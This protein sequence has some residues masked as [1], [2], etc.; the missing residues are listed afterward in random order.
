MTPT[1]PTL[2]ELSFQSANITVDEDDS[3][4]TVS[5]LLSQ[6]SGDTVTVDYA[7][8]DISAKAADDY[9]ETSGTLTFAAGEN[10]QGHHR[11]HPGRRR[12]RGQ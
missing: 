6:A 5:V 12:V 3:Q 8:S 11:T 1:P 4:A 7:T 9:T 2:P 10:R